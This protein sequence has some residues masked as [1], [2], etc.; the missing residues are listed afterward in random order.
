MRIAMTLPRIAVSVSLVRRTVAQAL[1]SARVARDCVEEAEIA[2]S[3][4][5]T[6]VYLHAGVGDHYEVVMDIA[7]EEL[8]IDILDS[9]AGVADRHRNPTMPDGRAE[10]GRGLLLMAAFTDRADFDLAPGNGSSVHLVKKL[11]WDTDRPKSVV[12]NAAK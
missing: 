11:V 8:T 6:N 10:N 3:E 5:C 2:V 7:D 4:A 12:I 9:G 1:R